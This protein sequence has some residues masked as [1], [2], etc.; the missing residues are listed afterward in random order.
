MINFGDIRK[1]VGFLQQSILNVVSYVYKIY[2]FNS[3]T[4][5]ITKNNP[6]H[7]EGMAIKGIAELLNC[8]KINQNGYEKSML[9]SLSS[10]LYVKISSVIYKR[11]IYAF[12]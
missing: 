2:L 11:Y 1:M 5:M 6:L 12:R 4:W 8:K 7:K 10:I 9:F 3:I